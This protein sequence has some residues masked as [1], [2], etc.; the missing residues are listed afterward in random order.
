[1][2]TRK[3]GPN[4]SK[5]AR[6]SKTRS[7]SDKQE[8]RGRE[9][10]TLRESD[11]ELSL[12][13]EET[14]ALYDRP[15]RT[16][17][18]PTQQPS[19]AGKEETHPA[20]A[21]LPLGKGEFRILLLAPGRREDKVTCS[22]VTASMSRPQEQGYEAISYLWGGDNE[23]RQ[24]P[25]DIKLKDSQG[26]VYSIFIRSTL[27][28]ALRSLRHPKDTRPFWVDAL[29]IN[30]SKPEEKNQQIAM[31]RYIFHNA[32][33][34]CFW[35]GEDANSKAA[36]AF[37]PRILDL[38]GIDRL[39]REDAAIDGWAAF[40]ALLK[41]TVF[42][43]L[44]LLQEVA[45]ARNVTLHCGQPAIHYADL[46]DAVAMFVSFRADISLLFL[47]NG[48]NCK[49]LSDRKM[50]MAERFI[51]LS[52]NALRVTS[53]GKIQRL[54][55][56][57]ALVSQLSDLSSSDH[58][59]RIFSVLAIAKDGPPLVKETL[60]E[61]P[62]DTRD[63]G[64]LRIDYGRS[65]LEVYQDFVVHAIERSQ[66]LD[67]I[68]RNWASSVSEKEVNLPTWV[69]PLQS[70]LQLPLDGNV[71]ER[72]AADSLVGF[73]DHNYYNASRGTVAKFLIE[74]QPFGKGKSLFA[75]GIHIDTISKLGPRASEGIILY[76]WLELGGCVT[77]SETVP[78]PENFWRTLVADRSPN[79]S[80]A[81]S[82]YTRAF[83]YCLHLTPTGDIN[84]NRLITECEAESSLVVAFLQRI[85]SVIWNRKFLV[86]KTNG[87]LGLAPMAAQV[88]DIICILYGCS[89][90]VV[91]RPQMAVGGEMYF[92]LV[93]EAYI[94]GMMD[95]EAI[96]ATRA[97]RYGEQEFEIQ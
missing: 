35:L 32:T 29:C 57:E 24:T 8:R 88:E 85:Q 15:V 30:R 53:S 58:R 78:P 83:L 18:V 13:D 20:T 36:L 62:T 37:I 79:G 94:H 34:L 71:S 74:S 64:D 89:V 77:V 4:L 10:S 2:N 49:E 72:T 44:W 9:S 91:L 46:V 3:R 97:G 52:T 28:A 5:T 66:S 60:M 19:L 95:G 6:R 21:Y 73:P 87:W 27:Y 22:F 61:Y 11:D 65:I 25:I 23:V 14:K 48:K 33:N 82:W 51:D 86:S 50:T 84:T 96:E 68:C 42:S 92:Q 7:T 38:A 45:V 47:R 43:R 76:E 90:P 55:S 31:K 69:R 70:S 16:A 39:V 80:N 63:E 81:P 67:I 41:N 40:V 12:S 75:R 93:G 26:K 54:L 17:A 59:D 1:M 56:L